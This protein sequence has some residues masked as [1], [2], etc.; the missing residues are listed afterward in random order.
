MRGAHLGPTHH[1][2]D[3]STFQV[4][5]EVDVDIDVETTPPPWI[6]ADEMT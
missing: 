2:L 6:S 4:L 3:T 5:T 1:L